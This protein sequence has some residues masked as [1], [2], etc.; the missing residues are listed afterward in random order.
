[1]P[2]E[3]NLVFVGTVPF[4]RTG[5]KGQVPFLKYNAAITELYGS[6]GTTIFDQAS[7][8]STWNIAH[9]LGRFPAVTVVDSSGREVD[10]EVLYTDANNVVLNFSA[11]FSGTAY[12]N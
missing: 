2:L 10:G 12:L 6:V 1:M 3:E 4:D 7:P 8:A 5:D 9:N 11:P